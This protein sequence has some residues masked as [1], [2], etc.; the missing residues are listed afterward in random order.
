M[1]TQYGKFGSYS[2]YAFVLAVGCA[3]NPAFAHSRGGNFDAPTIDGTANV[4][5]PQ[6]GEIVFDTNAHQ[7]MGRDDSGN[8]VA[9]SGSGGGSGV[10][11]VGTFSGSSQTNG[12][13]ISGSTI[14]FGPA[15][16]ANPGMVTVGAQTFSGPKTIDFG[17]NGK[18]VTEVDGYGALLIDSYTQ[19][20][21]P[22]SQFDGHD[23]HDNKVALIN[24]TSSQQIQM[25]DSGGITVGD[26]IASSGATL[27]V[28]GGGVKYT[29]NGATQPACGSSTQGMTWFVPSTGA[30]VQDHFQVCAQD[31]TNTFAWRN[32]Y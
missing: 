31:V 21:T 25:W 3:T 11:T 6:E 19:S 28:A 7:F 17:S 2:L 30:G 16:T 24:A 13:S 27:D 12:A 18:M 26:R 32:L 10:T 20:G 29:T 22:L 9:L 15:D 4:S 23:F 14:T 5:S 1:K 8:W